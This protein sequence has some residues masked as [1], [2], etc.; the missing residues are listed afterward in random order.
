M[1]ATKSLSKSVAEVPTGGKA[2]KIMRAD[3]SVLYRIGLENGGVVPDVLTGFYTSVS[4]AENA[5][6]KYLESRG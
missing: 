2:F 4:V 1:S 6:Q 5:V 3:G